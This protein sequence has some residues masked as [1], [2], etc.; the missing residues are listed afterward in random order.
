M[1]TKLAS[2]TEVGGGGLHIYIFFEVRTHVYWF[3]RAKGHVWA[4]LTTIFDLLDI[5]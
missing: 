3:R 1:L 2:A 4:S 5:P